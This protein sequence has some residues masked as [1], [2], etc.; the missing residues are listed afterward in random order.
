MKF[1]SLFLLFFTSSVI[2]GSSLYERG[3]V[4]Y[5]GS[6]KASV[7]YKKAFNIFGHAS[8]I[9][10]L[11]AQTA[12]GIMHIEGKGTA[13]NDQ[14]G[15]LLLEKS[16]DKGHAKAQYYLGA[17]YYLGIGVEQDFKKAHQWIKKAAL[18][19]HADAQNNL[20]QMY[21][22][23]KGTIKDLALANKWYAK[24]AKF[25]NKDSQYYLAKM[26]DKNKDYKNAH[27]WYE[28]AARRGHADAQYRLG[29]LYKKGN[30]VVQN[31]K[32]ALFWYEKASQS[33][34]VEVLGALGLIYNIGGLGVEKDHEKA[35]A[36]YQRFRDAKNL[37]SQEVINKEDYKV[38]IEKARNGDKTSQFKIAVMYKNGIGTERSIE[39]AKYWLKK[40]VKS[41]D[42]K[43]KIELNKLKE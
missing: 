26:H 2:A 35:Q 11:D 15:I 16:A 43:A 6:D 27:T 21:E 40:L 31:H 12:L 41:G 34:H 32:E 9:G 4:Y 13:Q 36:Y 33:N 7:D 17:M 38:H 20:A 3:K 24:S 1:L 22:V 28:K 18:Q 37:P 10:D 39:K 8:K 25:G 19:S 29:E 30:G 42:K 14:K 5:Y 23:G